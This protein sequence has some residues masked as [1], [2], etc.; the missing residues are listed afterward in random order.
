MVAQ[1]RPRVFRAKEV[2]LQ[3]QVI[4]DACCRQLRAHLL[5]VGIFA[6][7]EMIHQHT[8]LNTTTHSPL[9][10]SKDTLG[11]L[12]TVQGKILDMN[13]FFSGIN[14]YSDALEDIIIIRKYFYAI[15]TK[16]WEKAK[17][18]I[19]CNKWLIVGWYNRL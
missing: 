5:E 19:E 3:H 12:V 10:G 17:V 11:L 7:T 18:R 6:R 1:V 2:K 13:E 16:S 9:H 4:L 14:F 8:Y 15:A